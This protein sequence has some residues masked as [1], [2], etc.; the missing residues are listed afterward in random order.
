MDNDGYISNGELFQ[1]LWPHIFLCYLHRLDSVRVSIFY[2]KVSFVQMFRTQRNKQFM[3]S[4]VL[5]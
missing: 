3:L 2:I 1:V 4:T 5:S